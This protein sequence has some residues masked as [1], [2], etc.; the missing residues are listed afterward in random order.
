VT[1]NEYVFQSVTRKRFVVSSM[2]SRYTRLG[3]HGELAE[4]K[5]Q[6]TASAPREPMTSHGSVTL[7]RLFDIFWPSWSRRSD[8]HTTLRYGERPNTSVFTA[9]SE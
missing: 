8:R 4:A 1:K 9:R 2:F 7:P 3:V 6:R 5:F